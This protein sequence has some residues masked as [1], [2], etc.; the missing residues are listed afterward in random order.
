MIYKLASLLIFSSTFLLGDVTQ[1]QTI[2]IAV[3][4]INELSV[5]DRESEITISSA[6]VDLNSEYLQSPEISSS[7]YNFTT[8]DN[9]KKKITAKLAQAL[10]ENVEIFAF[11][12]GPNGSISQR[13]N[14]N[15][16]TPQ[17]LVSN[18][19]AN[20][21]DSTLSISYIMRATTQATP[22]T[23]LPSNVIFSIEDDI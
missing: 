5:T 12:A 20:S 21:K 18:I 3:G 22:F 11:L 9:N 4:P 13:I 16:E 8:I 1:N 15:S 7:T 14:V 17:T 19:S 6:D 23:N 10:P 2:Q